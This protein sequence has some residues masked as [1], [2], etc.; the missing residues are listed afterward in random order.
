[1]FDQYVVDFRKTGVKFWLQINGK[2][3]GN[4]KDGAIEDI[5]DAD[6]KHIA[7]DRPAEFI[8]DFYSKMGKNKWMGQ[9][10]GIKH[11]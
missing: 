4:K 2:L 1:M 10:N 3:L 7:G 9:P 8:D 6:G 11:E 5:R